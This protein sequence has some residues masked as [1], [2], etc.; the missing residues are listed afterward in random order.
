MSGN[1]VFNEVDDDVTEAEGHAPRLARLVADRLC[2]DLSGLLGTLMGAIEMT[3]DDTPEPG[4]ALLLADDAAR[5]LGMRLRLL[6]AAWA[7]DGTVRDGEGLTALMPGLPLGRRVRVDVSELRGGF[8]GPVGRTLLNLVLLG[9]E[10]LPGGGGVTLRGAWPD[11]I[12]VR[13]SGPRL[14]RPP[15]LSSHLAGLDPAPT[16][17]RDIQASLTFSAAAAAGARLSLGQDDAGL[18]LVVSAAP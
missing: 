18:T 15:S 14:A 11:G 16:G 9:T 17:P 7:G 12:A 2:H 5:E 4:E 8:P 3:I 6:R 13:A 10:S 1:V